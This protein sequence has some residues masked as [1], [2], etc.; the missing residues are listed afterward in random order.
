MSTPAAAHPEIRPRLGA[1]RWGSLGGKLCHR[2][3]M[4]EGVIAFGIGSA[5]RPPI[6]AGPSLAMQ[7]WFHGPGGSG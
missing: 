6:R 2:D 7:N 1:D 4:V 3:L 5:G